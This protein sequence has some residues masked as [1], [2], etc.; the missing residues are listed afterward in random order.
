MKKNS[1]EREREASFQ[2]SRYD[3]IDPHYRTLLL[4]TGPTKSNSDIW[5]E[6]SLAVLPLRAPRSALPLPATP[7]PTSLSNGFRSKGL[8]LE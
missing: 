8:L 2:T 4:A 5:R 7:S 3:R 6:L 1:I